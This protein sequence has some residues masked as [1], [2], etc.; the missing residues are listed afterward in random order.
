MNRG[1]VQG[2]DTRMHKEKQEI[3]ANYHEDYHEI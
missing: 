2:M 1:R 3:R